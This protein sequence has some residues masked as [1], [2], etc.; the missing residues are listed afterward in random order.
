[1]NITNLRENYPKLISHLENATY[2]R[3]YIYQFKREIKNILELADSG[4]VLCYADVYR[5]HEQAK[6]TKNILKQK[7]TV[8]GAIE[9]FDMFGKYPDGT[10][11]QNYLLKGSYYRLNAE[12]QAIIDYYVKTE[13]KRGIKPSTICSQ[14]NSAAA[15]LLALQQSGVERLADATEENVLAVYVA[16]DGKI[17]K[18]HSSKPQSSA[19]LKACIPV[20]PD[21]EKVLA[22]LPSF[23]RKRKNMQY[24]KS[25]EITKVK[26][27]LLDDVSSLTLRNRAIGIL[28]LYTGLRGCDITGLTMDSIDWENDILYIRQQKTEV[29]FTLPL[30]ATV[31]NAIYDYINKERPKTECNYIFISQNKP[32]GRIQKCKF[33]AAKIMKA[34][35]IRQESDSL[36]GLHI[37]RH[38]LVTKLLGNGIPRPVISN[39]VGHTSPNALEAYLSADFPH[40]K[41]C[42][43]SIDCFP[44]AK[45]VFS[46]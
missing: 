24:L 46:I 9:Q 37:F 30:S 21:C 2:N 35:N 11:K 25:E 41:E 14:S 15:F 10:Y 34:A 36:K 40:L 16:P 3:D 18:S 5:N 44:V 8:I 28:A 45:E 32:F 31:G 13:T 20:Y 43:I 42:A 19:F 6:C 26:R 1:M 29:P 27:V 12:Y 38:N 22:F 17:I 7:R 39:I 33:I 4:K 23:R